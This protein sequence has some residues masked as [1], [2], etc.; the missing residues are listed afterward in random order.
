MTGGDNTSWPRIHKRVISKK[1]QGHW[2]LEGLDGTL[3]L[4]INL[5]KNGVRV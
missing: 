5:K 3:I 4:Q 1:W 2:R